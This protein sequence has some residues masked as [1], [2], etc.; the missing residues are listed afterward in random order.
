[1]T[2]RGAPVA[3][4]LLERDELGIGQRAQIAVAA[5]PRLRERLL[6]ADPEDPPGVLV[7]DVLP[8]DVA[9]VPVEHVEGAVRADLQAEADPVARC[10]P[11]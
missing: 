10:S 8:A 4:T 11:S 7:Q 5:G 2:A 9:V 6:R 3:R 1:M